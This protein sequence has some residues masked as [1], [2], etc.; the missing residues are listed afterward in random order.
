MM[1]LLRRSTAVVQTEASWIVG[2][3]VETRAK[4]NQALNNCKNQ[5]GESGEIYKSVVRACV[6]ACL[7]MSTLD[8]LHA[9]AGFIRSQ[10]RA[11]LYF[12]RD[13]RKN[14]IIR[15]VTHALSLSHVRARGRIQSTERSVQKILFMLVVISV[16][17]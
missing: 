6:R 13:D 17:V 12:V 7:T 4:T 15:R 16:S 9:K 11:A 14:C 3:G 1:C 2:A 5:E 8:P 10:T